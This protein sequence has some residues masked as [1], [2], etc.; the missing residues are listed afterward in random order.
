MTTDTKTVAGVFPKAQ[1]IAALTD[2][3]ASEKLETETLAALA[4]EPKGKASILTPIIEIDS[5]RVV[6][7]LLEIEKVIG[8]DVPEKLIKSGG[9]ESFDELLADLVPKVEKL[10]IKGD[11]ND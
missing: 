7:A 6:R 10:V 2:W 9:Y 11:V 5:H 4:P 8:R 3:W 1:V